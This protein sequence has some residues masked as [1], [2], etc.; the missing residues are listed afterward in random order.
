[1]STQ[2][3]R[4]IL[5][6]AL[7]AGCTPLADPPGQDPSSNDETPPYVELTDPA[8][9]DSLSPGP[10]QIKVL[11][12]D[13]GGV[14]RVEIEV[15]GQSSKFATL[16]DGADDRGTFEI[17]WEAATGSH[18][19][20]AVA[21]DNAGNRATARAEISVG[22]GGGQCA[23]SGGET[24]DPVAMEDLG[25]FPSTTD[26]PQS[27]WDSA[28]P[29]SSLTP[30]DVDLGAYVHVPAGMVKERAY[31]L[32]VVLHG[33]WEDATIH[34]T[35]SQWSQLADRFHFY[36][37]YPENVAQGNEC[38]DWNS[39]ASQKGQEGT[40]SAAVMAMIEAVKGRYMVDADRIYVTGMSAGAALTVILLAEHPDQFAAGATHAGLPY[41]GYTGRG[42]KT[43][44][45]LFPQ[46]TKDEL[47]ADPTEGWKWRLA[48]LGAP[49]ANRTPGE[50]VARM[51]DQEKAYPPILAFYGTDDPTVNPEHT[52][53]L[54]EQWT[55]V[56]GADQKPDK[57][58]RLK[59]DDDSHTL[60]EY[61]DDEG[62]LLISTVEV[63]G[64]THAYPVD[65]N[66]TGDDAG[67]CDPAVEGSCLGAYDGG[68]PIFPFTGAFA[69]DK[70]FYSAYYI[71]QFFGLTDC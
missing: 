18:V 54:M 68:S 11:V 49:P 58:A 64:M 25:A 71:A 37:L 48:F 65:P 9:G 17:A 53:E 15:D 66:G 14:D 56:R 46:S 32:V 60:R 39:D 44:G 2:L 55:A 24:H 4:A 59:A 35:N 23:A 6:A 70:G 38:F 27:A 19:I 28:F 61:H 33:C 62:I 57:V 30:V 34:S 51:P 5:T 21:T 3:H 7:A 36:V 52:N 45:Y 42:D 12:I 20:E 43:L 41:R 26:F 16:T 31:P 47:S 67:G 10:R 29:S 50:W 69:S 1:M 8:D 40:D 13:E 63:Q 22:I